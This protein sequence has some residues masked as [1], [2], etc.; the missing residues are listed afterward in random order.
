ILV[1]SALVVYDFVAG[2]ETFP[3]IDDSQTNKIFASAQ[4]RLS[5]EIADQEVALAWLTERFE[6]LMT[7]SCDAG[8]V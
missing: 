4:S 3:M 1:A 6:S 8:D 2:T 7:T 5:G